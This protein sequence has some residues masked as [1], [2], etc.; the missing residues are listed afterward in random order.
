M[1]FAKNPADHLVEEWGDIPYRLIHRWLQEMLKNRHH[2]QR[3]F[4]A[5]YFWR[6]CRCC[7]DNDLDQMWLHRW[8]CICECM[9]FG[10][11][12]QSLHIFPFAVWTLFSLFQIWIMLRSI[13]TVHNFGC[14][15]GKRLTRYWPCQTVRFITP[16]GQGLLLNINILFRILL[17][18]Q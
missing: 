15:A 6:H 16:R 12:F 7:V 14:F 3:L 17:I 18:R 4:E 9:S 1:T 2:C 11:G 8:R 10:R 13:N 5:I